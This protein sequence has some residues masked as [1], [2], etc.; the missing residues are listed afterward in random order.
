MKI[1]IISHNLS[2]NNLVRVY[3]IGNVLKRI[4]DVEILGVIFGKGVFEP[5]K[6]EFDYKGITL[7]RTGGKF[8]FKKTAVFP[9]FSRILKQLVEM[10]DGDVI[11]AM[12]PMLSSLGVGIMGKFRKGIP[13]VLDIED[14]DAWPFQQYGFLEKLR[15][16]RTIHYPTNEWYPMFM[17]KLVALADEITVGSNYL[18]NKFG[19]TKLPHGTDCFFFDPS[20]YDSGAIRHEWKLDDKKVILFAGTPRPHKGLENL[21]T[22]IRTIDSASIK[23][24]F[25]GSQNEYWKKLFKN[26]VS[27]SIIS[28]GSVPHSN[29]PEVLG[30][31]DLIVIPQKKN[32][33]AEAQIPG[34]IFEAMAMAK[35]II[36]T[37]V[38]DLKEILDGCGWTIPPEDPAKLA[39]IIKYV[40][41]NPLTAKSMGRNARGVCIERYSW[42]AMEEILKQIFEK[43][44]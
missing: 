1:S 7:R 40:F 17:E 25:A 6:D 13:L 31:A 33:F 41:D 36:A 37:N 34:K 16:L 43:Y 10:I 30:M 5:Y 27:D 15:E 12:K 38:S 22:A 21:F 29:M 20:K 44:E 42:D 11:Y 39:Q 26:V 2:G 28:I 4:Y 19:G 23:L 35:P 8:S 24:V 32:L 9:G 14:F 18:Q 3:A